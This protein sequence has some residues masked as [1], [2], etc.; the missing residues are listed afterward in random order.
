MV[1]CSCRGETTTKGK[2]KKELKDCLTKSEL[3][4][5]WRYKFR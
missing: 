4:V 2:K 5:S 1:N 3:S